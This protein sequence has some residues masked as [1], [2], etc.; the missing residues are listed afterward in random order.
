MNIEL[1][2]CTLMKII[3]NKENVKIGFKIERREVE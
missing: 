2:F 3:E 1:F